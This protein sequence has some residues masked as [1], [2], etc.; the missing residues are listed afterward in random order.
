MK[1]NIFTGYLNFT[2]KQNNMWYVI[3]TTIF[4]GLIMAI[5]ILSLK[6]RRKRILGN[7][8]P[9]PKGSFIIGNLL[10][11]IQ[12]PE[13]LIKNGL[14]DYRMWARYYFVYIILERLRIKWCRNIWFD[15]NKNH[16]SI[17]YNYYWIQIRFKNLKLFLYLKLF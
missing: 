12:N 11:F 3:I 6:G 16:T 2:N 7:Q 4:S 9:G 13:A 8:L 15:V 17:L 14:T 10:F 5:S 1:N